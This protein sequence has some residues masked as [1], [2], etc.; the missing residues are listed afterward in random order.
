[1]DIVGTLSGLAVAGFVGLYGLGRIAYGMSDPQGSD[2]AARVALGGCAI[3]L[4]ALAFVGWIVWRTF[5]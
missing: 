1:M 5:Q 2:K 4:A 3:V